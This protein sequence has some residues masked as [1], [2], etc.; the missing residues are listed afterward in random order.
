MMLSAFTAVVCMLSFCSGS[1]GRKR[2]WR[3][4]AFF[5]LVI[6]AMDPAFTPA[7]WSLASGATEAEAT[8]AQ[9]LEGTQEPQ[10]TLT[11]A[12]PQ[13]VEGDDLEDDADEMVCLEVASSAGG[14]STTYVV[15]NMSGEYQCHVCMDFFARG[16][17]VQAGTK[18]RPKWRCHGDNSAMSR[19]TL[20]AKTPEE[21]KALSSLRKD[22]PRYVL[23]VLELK[24]SHSYGASQKQ[25]ISKLY[26]ALVVRNSMTKRQRKIE[27]DEDGYISYQR[28]MRNKTE[29]QAKQLWL[30]ES[31]NPEVFRKDNGKE[32]VVVTMPTEFIHDITI[33][34]MRRM[35]KELAELTDL[36]DKAAA[37]Q[38]LKAISS[39]STFHEMMNITAGGNFQEVENAHN[40][41]A[42]DAPKFDENTEIDDDA[43]MVGVSGSKRRRVGETAETA[44]F[45]IR[46]EVGLEKNKLL[47][48]ATEVKE[49]LS[50]AFTVYK[51][52][53]KS[54]AIT[55]LEADQQALLG[56]DELEQKYETVSLQML[57]STQIQHT[58]Y[59][60]PQKPNRNTYS[61]QYRLNAGFYIS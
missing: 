38:R 22:W 15:Q 49:K 46:Q 6:I 32:F 27:M 2:P 30:E 14:A 16:G 9:A 44:N 61:D 35:E 7:S 50:K 37:V 3:F 17:V 1:I 36:N 20:N 4:C 29:E 55:A 11:L 5:I 39:S 21:K 54:Q 12:L 33:E 43:V 8:L 57:Q 13:V 41:N 40:A 28:H 47:V 60:C 34:W 31:K 52:Y 56:T 18:G 45:R 10:A 42:R 26:E 53:V 25:E 24:S 48:R 19:L 58:N 51:R 23:K 59:C